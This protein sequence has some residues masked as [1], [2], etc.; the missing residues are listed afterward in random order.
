MNPQKGR[1]YKASR[2]DSK[3][4]VTLT[5]SVTQIR[6]EMAES[7]SQISE[8]SI[9]LLIDMAVIAVKL[10]ILS[11]YIALRGHISKAAGI[12]KT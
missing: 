5:S 3:L 10:R 12:W 1:P 2:V 4:T 11:V 8:G 6:G 7:C 9:Y